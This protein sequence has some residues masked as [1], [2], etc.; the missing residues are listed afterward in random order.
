MVV[1]WLLL[2]GHF[3]PLMSTA[4]FGSIH[5]VVV[6]T[7]SVRFLTDDVDWLFSGRPA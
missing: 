7:L 4:S 5:L 2:V 6:G 1:K 3:F